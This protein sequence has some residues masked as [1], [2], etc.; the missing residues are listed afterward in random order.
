MAVP[1]QDQR[2]WDFAE[3][4]D[5]PIIRTVAA[6]RRL[7]GRGLRRRGPGHQQPVARRP[8][9]RRGQGQGDR[10]ARGAGHRRAQG[11]LPPARLAA[12]A[13]ALL[14]LPDPDRVLPRPRRGA[15]A[16][17]RA[18]GAGAR[19]RRVP[20]RPASRRC[21]YHEGFL[22]TTCPI[23]GGPAVR[24]TDTMDTFVDSSWYFLRFCDP[25]NEDAAVRPGGRRQVDAGR[26]VHR[27]RSSTPSCT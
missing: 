9:R 4:H 12:V 10:V 15:G 21:S 14:G 6:A 17:R 13:P 5:L 26:P 23:C 1:G 24:E 16:R 2:D 27:R 19:R 7:R 11:Q 22:H 3:A 8:R 20:A 25:W 18:A